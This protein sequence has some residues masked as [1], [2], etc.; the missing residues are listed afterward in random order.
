MTGYWEKIS[1]G[2]LSSRGDDADALTGEILISD[3]LTDAGSSG[4]SRKL[5]LA[6]SKY[7]HADSNTEL[8]ILD[9]FGVFA[10]GRMGLEGEVNW[11][12]GK[13][14]SLAY[15]SAGGA[16]E[17][18]RCP[19]ISNPKKLYISCDSQSVDG[20]NI[21]VRARYQLSGES[22]LPINRQSCRKPKLLVCVDR[23]VRLPS[24]KLFLLR[25]DT[26]KAIQ[27]HLIM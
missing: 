14:K 20:L 6:F 26:V 8:R 19:E 7:D 27:M 3:E 18:Q 23:R 5:G 2:S 16:T 24:R 10:Y 13:T 17:A 12:T 1:E 22:R 4:L 25:A 11:P 21:L 9:I 15:S